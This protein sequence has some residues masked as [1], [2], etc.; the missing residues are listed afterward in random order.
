M[1]IEKFL[2]TARRRLHCLDLHAA[3]LQAAR[4]IHNGRDILVVC[5][6][7]GW[8]AGVLTKADVVRHTGR[9]VDTRCTALVME[10]MTRGVVIASPDDCVHDLWE[11]IRTR[12]VKDVPVL[13]PDGKPV[14]MLNARDI[15]H[16]LLQEVRQDEN[17]PQDYVSNIGYR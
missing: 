3:L 2:P 12:R 5:A 13:D 1:L 10:A 9:C 8:R 16:A 4:L 14:G 7:A 6:T 11:V 17:L 15:L